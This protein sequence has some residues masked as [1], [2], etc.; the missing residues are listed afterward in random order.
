MPAEFSWNYFSSPEGWARGTGNTLGSMAS[1]LLPTFAVPESAFATI[2]RGLTAIPKIGKLFSPQTASMTGRWF[3]SGIPEAAMEGGSW[4]R[5]AVANGMNPDEAWDKRWGVFGR[6]AAFLPISNAAQWGLFN[7]ALKG[8]NLLAG[9]G[10]L[11]SQAFEEGMQEAFTR[12]VSGLPNTWNPIEMM[13]D[14]R[15]AE[16][17]QAMKEGF[18]GFLLPTM[19]GT[20]VG[21]YRDNFTEAGR[22]RRDAERN[23]DK[24][25]SLGNK[26]YSVT[27][28]PGRGITADEPSN[29]LRSFGD[30]GYLTAQ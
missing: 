20:G 27:E 26:G 24:I 30:N 8:K 4:Y 16:Q 9:A 5:N 10:E 28:N 1:I 18:F 17:A 19:L 15:Y 14:P 12:E 13:T 11:G 25:R 2:G 21:M 22:T 3:A 29:D 7:K 6:N 23:S